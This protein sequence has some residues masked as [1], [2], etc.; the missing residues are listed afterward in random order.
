MRRCVVTAQPQPSNSA[1][2]SA[3]PSTSNLGARW[4][5]L[6]IYAFSAID[7]ALDSGPSEASAIL[8]EA[9]GELEGAIAQLDAL[10][11]GRAA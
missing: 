8:A 6:A 5:R 1:P 11:E 4:R 7:Q 9:A 3:Q 10:A 2:V